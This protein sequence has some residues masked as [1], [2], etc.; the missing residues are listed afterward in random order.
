MKT[1]AAILVET[2]KP[3][4]LDE[5]E[6]PKLKPGQVLIEVAFTGVCHTQILESRGYRGEDKF[7]P[8][9][10]GHEGSGLVRETGTAVTKVKQGDRVILSWMKGSGADVP[11]TI[12]H[13]NG[14]QVNAGAITTF[15]RL[16]VISENRLTPL[17]EEIA[18]GEAA[19]LGCALPTGVG[20]V[21]NTA[22]PAPGQ[23]IA[24]FGTGGVGLFAVS[25]AFLSGCA[26]IIAVDINREKLELAHRMGASHC[27]LAQERDPLAEIGRICPGGLDFA[28]EATGRPDVMKQALLSVHNQ[29][30]A[31]VLVGNA[32]YGEE[33]QLDPRQFN[34]GKRLLGTWGGDNA[35]DRDFP[36]Y[37]KLVVSGRLPLKPLISKTYSL[38]EINQAMDDLEK[39]KVARPV[40]EMEGS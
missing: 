39:G 9:C 32:R 25:G 21:V 33:L 16:A 34:L 18:M 37:C 40:V 24:I 19:L 4:V 2:G 22:R 11:G 7:L 31:A 12:Y 17:P 5:I 26:P 10:L 38:N 13:W 29:G 3:L 14:R 30:G 1:V 27:I 6:I 36:R 23:S 15:S 8:H 28:V 35:P 20:A